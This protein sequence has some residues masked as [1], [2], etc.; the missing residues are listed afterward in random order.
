MSVKK[1]LWSIFTLVII[2][3]AP[4]PV[5]AQRSE[6]FI[7]INKDANGS[8]LSFD[9]SILTLRKNDL[10][11]ALVSAVHIGEADYYTTLNRKFKEYEAVLYELIADADQKP[12]ASAEKELSAIS[13][14]QH[15]MK[16]LLGLEFQL[17]LIDYHS[18]NFIHAD[19][20]PHEFAESME[21]KN[22]SIWSMLL[23][24]L[25]RSGEVQA[26]GPQITPEIFMLQMALSPNRTMTLRRI[27]AGQFQNMDTFIEVFEGKEGSSIITE[28][29]KFAINVLKN[30][31]AAGKKKIAIFYGAGHMK[32]LYTRIAN[33]LGAVESNREW[34]VAWKLR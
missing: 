23:K 13:H 28:R 25:L 4:P 1:R 6:D 32:D 16:G 34:I 31:I 5:F 14:L 19:M 29:N 12:S 24:M 11:I 2:T 7:R 8:Y 27:L 17:D 26:K 22:E 30:Q 3:G 15:G 18:D 10:E 20:T 21:R 9:S 33:E